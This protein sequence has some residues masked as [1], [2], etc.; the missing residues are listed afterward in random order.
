MASKNIIFKKIL[1]SIYVLAISL[2]PPLFSTKRIE[3]YCKKYINNNKEIYFP[4]KFL[5]E[6]Y[7]F[8][9]EKNKSSVTY[10]ELGKDIGINKSDFKKLYLSIVHILN[11]ILIDENLKILGSIFTP[12][13]GL[14]FYYDDLKN[15]LMLQFLYSISVLR[16]NEIYQK[17]IDAVSNAMEFF[18]KEEKLIILKAE[19]FH[20]IGD[21]ESEINE[22]K[23]LVSLFPF[24]SKHR[25]FLAGLEYLYGDKNNA[26]NLLR[27]AVDISNDLHE[28]E[29]IQQK[30]SE[31]FETSGN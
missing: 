20:D 28:K 3:R 8:V 14:E 13:K 11:N 26:K 22:N 18:G 23:I 5:A 2:W 30:I 21:Y 16:E 7:A 27:Q 19:I 24:K 25:V 4:R 15:E 9:G 29:K 6:L 10:F 17:S 31:W 1:F 12:L